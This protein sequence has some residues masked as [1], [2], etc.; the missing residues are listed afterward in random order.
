MDTFKIKIA[1]CVC[2]SRVCFAVNSI[3]L[4][5]LVVE[6]HGIHFKMLFGLT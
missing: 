6:T 3:N 5:V 1:W 4:L 2:V